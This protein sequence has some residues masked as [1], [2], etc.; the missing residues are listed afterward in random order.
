MINIKRRKNGKFKHRH[1]VIK[2]LSL[3]FNRSL[4]IYNSDKQCLILNE[5]YIYVSF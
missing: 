1:R 3:L 2:L 5:N 4:I